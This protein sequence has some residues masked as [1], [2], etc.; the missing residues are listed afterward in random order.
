MLDGRLR[1]V[2]EAAQ[3]FRAPVSEAVARFV[4]VETLVECRVRSVS[5]GLAV[6]ESG[7]RTI[8]VAQPAEPGEWVRLC[9]RPEDVT[10][11]TRADGGPSSARN[12]LPGRVVRLAAAGAHVRVTID[13][14][15]P[16]VALVTQRSV[17]EMALAAGSSVT[18]HFKATAPHLLRHAKP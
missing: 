2:D 15:F 3:V 13:C 9:I 4:G 6:L 18:A 11:A 12:H 5:D 17:D 10:L 8:E 1:Q 16:L 7:D 14:G